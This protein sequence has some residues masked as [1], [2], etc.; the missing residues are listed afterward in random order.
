ML[1]KEL[2]CPARLAGQFSFS[3]STAG[4]LALAE[5]SRLDSV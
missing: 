3:G 2:L 5:G 4:T 1:R